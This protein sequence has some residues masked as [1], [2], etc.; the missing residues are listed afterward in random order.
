MIQFRVDGGQVTTSLESR[1]DAG[2][3]EITYTVSDGSDKVYIDGGSGADTLTINAH[4]PS[5]TVYDRR[6]NMLY[7]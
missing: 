6:G 5:F 3:D 4:A 7:Q 2:K 1:L